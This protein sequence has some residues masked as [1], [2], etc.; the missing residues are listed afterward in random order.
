MRKYFIRSCFCEGERT[1]QRN[2]SFVVLACV[3][4]LNAVRASN[5][6]T[7]DARNDFSSVNNP[8]GAWSYGYSYSLGGSMKVYPNY[9][10][11]I[12]TGTYAWRDESLNSYWG[13]P[14]VTRWDVTYWGFNVGADDLTFHPG[15][16]GEYSIVRWTAPTDGTSNVT[17]QFASIHFG[18]QEECVYHNT[19]M[20][21]D[22]VT[23]NYSVAPPYNS[24]F[25]V[26]AGDTIDFT[27]GAM[28]DESGDTTAFSAVIDFVPVPEPSTFVLL[29]MGAIGLFGF[30][31]RRRHS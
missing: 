22:T 29:G 25:S 30:A 7:Y 12:I 20:L 23:S 4:F 27:V 3:L 26:H 9:S 13:T 19:E 31:S 28:G 16:N 11:D 18:T 15:P 17:A 21:F 1:M 2:F 8:T 24:S 6:Q 14:S 5:G 10:N